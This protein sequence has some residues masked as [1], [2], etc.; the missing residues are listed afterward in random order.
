MA[1]SDLCAASCHDRL[2]GDGETDGSGE[3]P[4]AMVFAAAESEK[5]DRTRVGDP[6]PRIVGD[7]TVDLRS[8][9]ASSRRVADAGDVDSSS[10]RRRS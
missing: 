5:T 1:A 3:P 9:G 6:P 7:E 4:R 10:H 8:V 2:S